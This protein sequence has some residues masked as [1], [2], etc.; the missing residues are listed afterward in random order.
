MRSKIVALVTSWGLWVWFGVFLWQNYAYIY[1][2]VKEVAV[3]VIAFICL[4]ICWIV[5]GVLFSYWVWN[6]K[7]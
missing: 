3:S 7:Q 5:A 1:S 4:L 2:G 6:N